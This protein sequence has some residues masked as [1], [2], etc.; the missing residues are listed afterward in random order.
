MAG[1]QSC[2]P[3][4]KQPVHFSL[5][6]TLSPRK[7]LRKG[8]RASQMVTSVHLRFPIEI[9]ALTHSQK[10]SG[11]FPGCSPRCIHRIEKEVHK[12]AAGFGR[13]GKAESGSGCAEHVSWQEALCK[14]YVPPAIHK[15][16]LLSPIVTELAGCQALQH[17][18]TEPSCC[19]YEVDP[20]VTILAVFVEDLRCR[21]QA[22]SSRSL[23]GRGGARIL[24]I[25]LGSPP[26]N[27]ERRCRLL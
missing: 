10:V 2:F 3:S 23:R 19:P 17:Y 9:P 13:T 15:L 4:P 1:Q 11:P 7:G 26:A 8:L 14:K 12:R 22:M 16:P 24:F 21:G 5:S 6:H 20:I 18:V 25:G 27:S